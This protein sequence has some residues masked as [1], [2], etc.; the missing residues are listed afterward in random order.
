M[1]KPRKEFIDIL[2]GTIALIIDIFSDCLEF[3]E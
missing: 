2:E 3:E 1:M